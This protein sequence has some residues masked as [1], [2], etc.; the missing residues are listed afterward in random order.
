MQI[1]KTEIG[2][3]ISSFV[4]TSP[5]QFSIPTPVFY[6]INVKLFPT[7]VSRTV[8]RSSTKLQDASMPSCYEDRVVLIVK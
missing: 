2:D 8:Y 7:Y 3:E 1:G 6:I 4:H 5:I